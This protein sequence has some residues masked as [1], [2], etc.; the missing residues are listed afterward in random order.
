LRRFIG[1]LCLCPLLA[2]G[3][4][5]GEAVGIHKP[6]KNDYEEPKQLGEAASTFPAYPKESDLI[7]FYVGPRA[8][9]RF[10]VDANSL[11]AG[12]DGIVRYTL[13]VKTAGGATNISY[14]GIQCSARQFKIYATG[15]ADGTW[16]GNRLAAWRPIEN[17]LVNRY[18]AALNHDFF[19]PID[20]PIRSSAE[21]L[22]ALRRGKHPLVP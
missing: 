6:V 10:F 18:H 4:E 15:N 1:L 22:D 9:N 8:T 5:I 2:A 12:G 7:E 3:G 13:V 16:A 19:C 11:S 20:N 17:E 21:G 14:E